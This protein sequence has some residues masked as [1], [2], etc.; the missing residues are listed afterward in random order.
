[1]DHRTVC[2]ALGSPDPAQRFLSEIDKAPAHELLTV[3]AKWERIAE[4]TLLPVERGEQFPGEWADATHRILDQS[5]S[6]TR[7]RLTLR[8][9]RPPRPATAPFRRTQA[10]TS[11]GPS[12]PACGR[13]LDATHPYGA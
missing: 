1:M 13:P 3:F 4:S 12:P 2:E 5:G 6:R 7:R 9:T 11:R 10:G 8:R